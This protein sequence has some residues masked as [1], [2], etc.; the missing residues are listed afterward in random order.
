MQ[1]QHT[2]RVVSLGAL[3]CLMLFVG[4]DYGRPSSDEVTLRSRLAADV[5]LAAEGRLAQKQESLAALSDISGGNGPNA[6]GNVALEQ[7]ASAAAAAA[8][9]EELPG[10]APP[11]VA[12]A[13]PS[14]GGEGANAGRVAKAMTVV[15]MMENALGISNPAMLA[16]MPK[17]IQNLVMQSAT[18]VAS[19]PSPAGS[20]GAPAQYPMMQEQSAQTAVAQAAAAAAEGRTAAAPAAVSAPAASTLGDWHTAVDPATGRD[21]YY[22]LK[23]N[24]VSWEPPVEPAP[25]S[26]AAPAAGGAG[27]AGGAEPAVGHGGRGATAEFGLVRMHPRMDAAIAAADKE[28]EGELISGA[29]YA[30]A[31]GLLLCLAA[32]AVKVLLRKVAPRSS[33]KVGAPPVG[34]GAEA[35]AAYGGAPT[36]QRSGQELWDTVQR[37]MREGRLE[38]AGGGLETLADA[39]EE[40]PTLVDIMSQGLQA[41]LDVQQSV[42]GLLGGDDEEADGPPEAIVLHAARADGDAAGD[43]AAARLVD[44][45]EE[46]GAVVRYMGADDDSGE[47]GAELEAQEAERLAAVAS[48]S[49]V[50]VLADDTLAAPAR[51]ASLRR[52]AVAA[53]CAAVQA[54]PQLLLLHPHDA[55]FAKDLIAELG[56]A[57]PGAE[58]R[59][60]LRRA[61][62]VDPPAARALALLAQDE[63]ARDEAGGGGGGGGGGVP[64]AA[65][66]R[67]VTARLIS[68]AQ[69]L[70]ARLRA[71]AAEHKQGRGGR[72]ERRAEELWGAGPRAEPGGGSSSADA[73]RPSPRA[74]GAAHAGRAA[75]GEGG[76]PLLPATF[77]RPAIRFDKLR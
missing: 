43:V 61:Q 20:M 25:A 27:G 63:A 36:E 2:L 51:G 24:Q 50:L 10:G 19:E 40:V 49:V 22:N 14:I 18:V 31:A 44:A 70:H 35:G 54:R 21:Y 75:P 55:G 62:D 68:S 56:A 72:R 45:L 32:G 8:A 15:K 9:K 3:L 28:A 16:G 34:A 48:A 60:A 57:A 37:G 39:V 33:P 6:L 64:A 77:S 59:S 30:L 69:G 71:R 76:R 42:L 17:S 58:H 74:R 65:R 66:G 13:M 47:G 52:L 7:F 73:R 38:A 23:T 26:D 53:H 5:K 11:G 41:A 46:G 67:E 4:L 1:R 12:A 29:A